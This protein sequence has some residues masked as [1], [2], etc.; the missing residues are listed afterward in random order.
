MSQKLWG[1][2][3]PGPKFVEIGISKHSCWLCE[4]YLEFLMQSSGFD[5]L[6]LVVTGYQ[7][8]IHSGWMAPPNGPINALCSMACL[9]RGELDEISENV[10]REIRSDSFPRDS[11]GDD[12]EP[13]MG[14][15]SENIWDI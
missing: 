11:S 6:R 10:E 13:K 15:K 7:G 3:R 1:Q 5:K 12:E 4:K 8:K 14:A 9:I 2:E